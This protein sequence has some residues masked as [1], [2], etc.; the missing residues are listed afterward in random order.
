MA[1]SLIVHTS[2]RG[3]ASVT[4][5]LTDR[6]AAKLPGTATV[7]DL[8]EGLPLLDA[9][10]IG[11]NFTE[12][13]KRTPEQQETLG[14]SDALIAEVQEADTLVIGLPIWN[15]GTPAVLKA[16]IDLIARARVTFRYGPNGP[17]GLLEGKR[18]F[19]VVA[20]GGTSLDSA[21]DFATPYLRH[22]LSFLGVTDVTVIDASGAM[23]RGEA[24]RI[25]AEAQ[26][27]A[28]DAAKVA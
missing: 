12:D 10:W 14:L 27:D 7:R 8:G 22:A 5:A 17:E 15:F 16:W 25:E 23:V 21:V 26:I 20:S 3:E 1:H 9:Q 4:R 11:A 24:A 28:I 18:A 13:A 2:P 6:L 19:V